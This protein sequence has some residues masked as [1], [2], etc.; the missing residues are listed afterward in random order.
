[1]KTAWCVLVSVLCCLLL[2]PPTGLAQQD[3]CE[4]AYLPFQEGKT[5]ELSNYDKKGKLTSTV[6]HTVAEVDKSSEAWTAKVRMEIMDKK[7][8]ETSSGTYTISCSDGVITMDVSY[9]LDPATMEAMGNFEVE[10][11]GKALEFPSQLSAGQTLPD[12]DMEIKGKSGGV[13]LMNMRMDVTDRKVDGFETVT[14]PAGTFECVK[15]TQ[16]NE[17]KMLVKNT[18]TSVTWM[19]K[20]VGTVKSESYDR[21]GNLVSS[22]LLTDI[23]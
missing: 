8:K 6:R 21:R 9:L 12:A 15:I 3:L 23:R 2:A 18:Y 1:M 13:T 4:S 17:M 16:T 20:G 22:T 7:G 19:A 11:S 10:M 14:T 5:F